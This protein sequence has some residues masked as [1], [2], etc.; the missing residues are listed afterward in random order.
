VQLDAAPPDAAVAASV[1][2]A[3]SRDAVA[4]T[5]LSSYVAV[6]TSAGTS[7]HLGA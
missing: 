1:G 6:A 7:D 5:E 4:C 2:V 3:P